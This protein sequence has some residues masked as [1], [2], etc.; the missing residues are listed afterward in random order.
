[1]RSATLKEEKE[2]SPERQRRD[3]KGRRNIRRR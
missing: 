2:E 3:E 1:M